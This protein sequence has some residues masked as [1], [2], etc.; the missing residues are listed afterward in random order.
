MDHD[1]R[2][3]IVARHRRSS[4]G[5]DGRSRARSEKGSGLPAAFVAGLVICLIVAGIVVLL[6]RHSKA[7]QQ[8][9]NPPKLPFGQA[10]QAYAPNIQFSKIKLAKAEN[11]LGEEFTYVQFTMKNAGT[12]SIEGLTIRLEFYDP[13]KQVVLRDNEQLVGPNDPPLRPTEERGLQITLG[14][15]PPQWNHEN[16]VFHVTGLILK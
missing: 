8:R 15:I 3:P 5:D 16:P 6:S 13:F 10:E 14:G 7:P 9:A 4:A 12:Q 11:F 1:M 2:T